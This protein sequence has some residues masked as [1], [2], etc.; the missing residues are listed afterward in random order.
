MALSGDVQITILDGQA[1]VVIVPAAQVQVVIGCATSGTVGQIVSTKSTQTLLSTFASGPLME[2]AGLIVQAGGVV[3]AM[4]ATT[5]TPG[6]IL[7]QSN[8]PLTVSGATNATPIVITTTTD[9]A[10]VTGSVVTVAGVGGNT[11]ANGTFRVT[12]LTATTFSLDGS[13]GNGVYTSGGTVEFE[14]VIQSGTGTSEITATGTPV[15]EAHVLFSVVAG[16]TVGVAG[17][18]FKVS[19]DA[20]RNYGP[21]FALGTANTYAIPGTGVTLNLS[22]GTLVA[23]DAARFTCTAPAMDAT[24][25]AA[26]LTTLLASQYAQTGWGSIHIVGATSGT[27]A[28]AIDNSGT[29]ALDDFAAGYVF[30]RAIVGARDAL[31]PPA[32]G[33]AGETEATW[34]AAVIADFAAVSAKRVSCAVGHYNVPSAFPTTAAGTPRKRRSLA[35]AYAARQVTIPQQRHAGR[36]KDGA[37]T[38]I[39][40]DPVNDPADGFLYHD[41]RVNPGFD[42]LTGG[43]GRFTSARTRIGLGSSG[44]FFLVNPLLLSPLGSDFQLLPQGL[45]MDV[46]CGI[47]H[48]VAQQYVNDDLRVNPNGTLSDADALEIKNAVISAITARMTGVAMISGVSVAV[49]Q[50]QNILVTKTVVITVTILGVAYVL[51]IDASLAFANQLAA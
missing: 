44:G 48:Q 32:W 9:H 45:V 6:A 38:Q 4:R 19:L 47:T 40:V 42:F 49:D 31:T 25:I 41:E 51:Q 33:G 23:G 50:T 24:G 43:T 20:G 12:V 29:K 34:M 1:G 35:W 36:V 21:V 27:L 14:G 26:A 2:A 18:T 46:A 39:V 13:V 16:G 10:L 28:T 7:G 37:L 17:I 30:T 22:A 5:A 8:A 15:D 3:L 11:G